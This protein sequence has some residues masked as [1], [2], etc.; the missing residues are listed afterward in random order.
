M[1][2]LLNINCFV[3]N[4]YLEEIDLSASD[5]PLWSSSF[6]SMNKRIS[7]STEN[8]KN[9]IPGSNQNFLSPPAFLFASSLQN[10]LHVLMR[11]G[12]YYAIDIA[13][14]SKHEK[15]PEPIQIFAGS[16]TSGSS[17]S[18]SNKRGKFVLA[19]GLYK[20]WE[21]QESRSNITVLTSEATFEMCFIDLE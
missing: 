12:E 6:A 7:L 1:L 2:A 10:V 3:Q 13:A 16:N 4:S 5:C 14:A 19:A 21:K 15:V 18:S 8:S 20:P 11:N 9:F 17:S